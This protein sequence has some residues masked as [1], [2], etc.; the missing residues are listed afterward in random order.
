MKNTSNSL[1][2]QLGNLLIK[3][4]SSNVNFRKKKNTNSLETNIELAEKD[5]FKPSNYNKIKEN[6][7]IEEKK[8]FKSI[9]NNKLR[10]YRFQNKGSHFVVLD[11]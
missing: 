10:P 11:N 2:L 6:N 7:T 5:L 1:V 9:Q 8:V 4:K 3:A